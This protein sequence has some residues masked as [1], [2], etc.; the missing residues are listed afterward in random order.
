MQSSSPFSAIIDICVS[1]SRALNGVNH[2]K[3][4]TFLPFLLYVGLPIAFFAFYFLGHDFDS[5]KEQFM[6]PLADKSP[7]ERQNA[8]A[9]LTPHTLLVTTC[10]T[11]LVGS[12]VI[13]CLH[14]LYLM[15]ATKVD[16]ENTHGF[17]DWFALAVWAR[18]P[19]LLSSLVS[20]LVV[21]I[22]TPLPTLADA[23]LFSLNA[24]LSLEPT[25]PWANLANT[26]T[27]FTFWG[28]F[29]SAL[30]I[31]LWTRIDKTRAWVIATLPYVV[32]YGAWAVFIFFTKG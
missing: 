6:A 9:F 25:D 13:F 20:F 26:L 29:L 19:E 17:G 16:D 8:E 21:A 11:V 27:L 3:Y 12:L 24:L 23:N 22:S 5:I 31:T 10:L 7:A 2:S 28:V 4:W 1:P 18:A 15:F 30:G 32:V 14:G